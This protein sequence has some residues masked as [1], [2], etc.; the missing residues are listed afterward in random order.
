MCFILWSEI[1][2]FQSSILLSEPSIYAL[3]VYPA[4]IDSRRV[5]RLSHTVA[6]AII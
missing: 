6:L 2:S 3:I 1:N 5:L 4:I